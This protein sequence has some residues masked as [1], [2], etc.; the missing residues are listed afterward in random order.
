MLKRTVQVL[1]KWMTATGCN[2][3]TR[4]KS[5]TELKRCCALGNEAPICSHPIPATSQAKFLLPGELLLS[6]STWYPQ[7]LNVS[8]DSGAN[9]FAQSLNIPLEQPPIL[10]ALYL[11]DKTLVRAGPC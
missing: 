10:Q 3:A 2:H 1:S 9:C 7:K 6:E 4:E 8:L 5:P 11:A